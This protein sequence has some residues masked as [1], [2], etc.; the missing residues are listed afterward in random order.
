MWSS[1]KEGEAGDVAFRDLRAFLECRQPFSMLFVVSDSWRWVRRPPQERL[2]NHPDVSEVLGGG[3]G[4]S[5]RLGYEGVGQ[6]TRWA[7]GMMEPACF[8]SGSSSG[9]RWR[10]MACA[11]SRRCNPAQLPNAAGI[12]KIGGRRHAAGMWNRG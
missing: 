2:G 10:G 11:A 4:G 6:E 12:S 7:G 3:E 1:L 8:A 9:N 5:L